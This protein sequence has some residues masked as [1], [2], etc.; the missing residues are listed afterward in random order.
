[1]RMSNIYFDN[2]ARIGKLYLEYV[3]YEFENEPI[4]FLCSDEEKKMYICLC[5]DIRY[6][7]KWIVVECGMSTLKSL[8]KEEIDI[9]SAFLI[10]KEAIVINMDLQGNESS[11]QI[12][13]DKVDRLDL[14]KEGTFIRC[15]K[16]K[17]QDYLWKKEVEILSAQL[18]VVMDMSPIID[19]IIR[20][21]NAS[22]CASI[23][24]LSK[25]M[26]LYADSVSKGFVEQFDKIDETLRKTMTIKREYSISTKEKYV[27]AVDNIDVN[28]SDTDD[29]LQAA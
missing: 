18:K 23:N 29:Y 10:S 12:D 2:V 16:E 3:F 17:A 27:E 14:P 26:E 11:F 28:K 19:E 1:M 6:G 24:I 21:Y 7:Q 13:I 20:T 22:F 9:V 8:I 15:D 4:L 25:Q 5:S